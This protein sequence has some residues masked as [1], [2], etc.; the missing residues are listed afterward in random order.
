MNRSFRVVGFLAFTG[1]AVAFA[2]WSAR[3][4]STRHSGHETL[5]DTIK[6]KRIAAIAT[7]VPSPPGPVG[8]QPLDAAPG[9]H[10]HVS[11]MLP[12]GLYSASPH[13]NLIEVPTPVDGAFLR[14]APNG[15]EFAMRYCEPPWVPANREQHGFDRQMRKPEPTP[16]W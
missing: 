6:P 11:E 3:T 12:P 1:V 15:L 4:P 14:Q 2:L 13:S 5:G 16:R 9:Y 8:S 10:A 7:V